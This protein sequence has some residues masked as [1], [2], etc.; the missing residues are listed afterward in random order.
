MTKYR[1]EWTQLLK[2]TAIVDAGSEQEAEDLFFKGSFDD[3]NEKEQSID[4]D[5]II[6]TE[7]D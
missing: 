5:S 6:I 3:V 2:F 1:I 4:N 7:V